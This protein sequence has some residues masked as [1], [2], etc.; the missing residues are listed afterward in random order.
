MPPIT[1]CENMTPT[2][3]AAIGPTMP[4]SPISTTGPNTIEFTVGTTMPSSVAANVAATT[5]T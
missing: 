2:S 4:K 5:V 3:S 1:T